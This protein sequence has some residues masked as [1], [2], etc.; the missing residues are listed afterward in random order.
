MT[1]RTIQTAVSRSPEPDG[2][3]KLPAAKPREQ[4]LVILQRGYGDRVQRRA[5]QVHQGGADGI[6]VQDPGGR[7]GGALGPRL[8]GHRGQ[9]GG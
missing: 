8:H 1:A 9:H 6:G 7:R 3:W 5:L 2:A 4:V